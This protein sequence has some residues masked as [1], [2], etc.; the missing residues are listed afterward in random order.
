[1][2]ECKRN[3]F[4]GKIRTS[5][6]SVNSAIQAATHTK[7]KLQL[8]I[9]PIVSEL[10]FRFQMEHIESSSRTELGQLVLARFHNIARQ[11]QAEK[12]A[13]IL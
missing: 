3:G 10:A 13:R 5:N 12:K 6:I 9:E 1:M 2:L 7:Q 11:S 4:P 8:P